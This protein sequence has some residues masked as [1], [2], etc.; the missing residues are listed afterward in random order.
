M[1]TIYEPLP[2]TGDQTIDREI[3]A[4][5]RLMESQ[6]SDLSG[7]GLDDDSIAA[8]LDGRYGTAVQESVKSFL[9][10]QRAF[11]DMLSTVREKIVTRQNREKAAKTN[12][13]E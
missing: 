9:S 12:R 2:T 10:A 11:E 7:I 1:N 3:N 8:A 6:V 13:A 4:V 5:N